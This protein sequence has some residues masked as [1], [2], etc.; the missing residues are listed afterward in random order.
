MGSEIANVMRKPYK[1]K[2]EVLNDRDSNADVH[3]CACESVGVLHV[4]L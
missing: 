1:Q 2:L 4:L 3:F